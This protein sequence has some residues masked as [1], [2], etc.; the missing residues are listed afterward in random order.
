M[1]GSQPH[2]RLRAYETLMVSPQIPRPPR[3]HPFLEVAGQLGHAVLDLVLPAQCHLCD[4]PASPRFERVLCEM[5]AND[6]PEVPAG[7]P[8]C[9]E[10]TAPD[11]EDEAL[12]PGTDLATLRPDPL[13]PCARCQS[14]PPPFHSARALA[15]YQTPL[16]AVVH[17]FKYLG[18]REVAD[19]AGK[20]MAEA[21]PARFPTQRFDAVVPIPLHW[22]RRFSRGYNQAE[23]LARPIAALWQ[24]PLELGVIRREST[25]RQAQLKS[26][27]RQEN[28]REAFEVTSDAARRLR[29]QRILLIDDV[30]TTGATV[31][32]C[33]ERLLHAGAAQ[34]DVYTLARTPLKEG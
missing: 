10:P 4:A 5:C 16:P 22:R 31:S 26:V 11:D 9:G 33:A 25:R 17:A 32:A 3:R 30:F 29:Q 34:V 1:D 14:A 27:E 20:R 13:R 19:L 8:L 2:F 28:I 15:L 12:S 24:L 7:C 23:R 6:W 18:R 21:L